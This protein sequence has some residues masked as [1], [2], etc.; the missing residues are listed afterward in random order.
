M[1]TWR[2]IVLPVCII[3]VYVEDFL[4]MHFSIVN[5]QG[6][7]QRRDNPS[8]AQ[9]ANIQI[10]GTYTRVF[11]MECMTLP[12]PGLFWPPPTEPYPEASKGHSWP[13]PFSHPILTGLWL[14]LP[15]TH[16]HFLPSYSN[17]IWSHYLVPRG[18]PASITAFHPCSSLK[19]DGSLKM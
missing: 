16:G 11:N 19:Q 1:F 14:Y 4:G 6:M 5:G 15:I 10:S 9:I 2:M 13:C 12:Q 8:E 18:L 3:H 17:T 7:C